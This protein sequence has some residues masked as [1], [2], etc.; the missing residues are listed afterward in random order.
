MNDT[1]TL[2]TPV[3]LE[4]TIELLGIQPGGHYIDCTLGT[5]GHAIAILERSLLGSRLLGI[6]VDPEAIEIAKRRLKPYGKAVVL[7]NGNFRYLGDICKR[8]DFYPV[9]GILFDLGMSSIQLENSSRGFSFK[10][11]ASLDMRFSPWQPITAAS[12][13]NK[14]PE[15]ELASLLER[16]GEERRSRLIAKSIVSNRPIMT[17]TQLVGAVKRA[18][19]DNYSKIHPATKT[20]QALRI[21]VNEELT[22]LKLALEQIPNLLVPGGRLVVISYHSLE[23]RLV[24]EFMRRESTG[25]LCPPGTP[26]CICGHTPTSKLVRRKV[27]T[28][29]IAEIE[30]NPRS[31]SAKLRAL[32]RL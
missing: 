1:I 12:I 13:V 30:A 14:F 10:H 27:I 8:Y 15:A 4:E 31:R 9:H 6:D 32:E 24:K 7:A 17:T 5:A 18:I 3:L 23:D 25:C 16:Y 19:G 11:D 2:H 26:I 20:F 29:S 28:P 22:N 21:A